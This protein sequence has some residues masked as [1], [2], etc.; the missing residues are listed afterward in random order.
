MINDK[1][2]R[3]TNIKMFSKSGIIG[4]SILGMVVYL[5]TFLS[6]IYV[7][8]KKIDIWTIFIGGAGGTLLSGL[9][10]VILFSIFHRFFG[11]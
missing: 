6:I 8:P 11:K 4:F 7:I 5:L 9:F 1:L 2:R 3:Q 10:I